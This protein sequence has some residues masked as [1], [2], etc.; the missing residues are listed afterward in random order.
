MKDSL[1]QRIAEI[2][3]E[4]IAYA[5]VALVFGIIRILLVPELR[6][7]KNIV[8]VFVICIPV[9]SLAGWTC[10]YYGV[11][12]PLCF[13]ACATTSL[14]SEKIIQ[15]ILNNSDYFVNLFKRAGEN[16]TDK[17]TK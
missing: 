13:V 11:P 3:P 14:L 10:M 4:L 9:A 7:F 1:I 2:I 16:L 6:G 5:V 15:A 8:T 17:W 12:D